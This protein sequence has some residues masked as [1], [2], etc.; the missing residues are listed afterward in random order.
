M[1]QRIDDLDRENET[2]RDEIADLED[3]KE[4]LEERLDRADDRNRSTEMEYKEQKVQFF[5]HHLCF[6][7][8][9]LWSPMYM[10]YPVVYKTLF[11]IR[12][13]S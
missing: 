4:K 13:H 3:M 9:L 8:R 5:L 2:L 12:P 1:L 7:V 6:S 11:F 10:P